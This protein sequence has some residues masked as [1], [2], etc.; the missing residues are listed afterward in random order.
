MSTILVTGAN[1]QLGSDISASLSSK[2][3]KVIACTRETFNLEDHAQTENVLMQ[4]KPEIVINTAA[5]HHVEQCEADEK[6][7]MLM[8][9]ET[10]QLMARVCSKINSRLIHFSTDYVFDGKKN[11]PYLET[12]ATAPLNVYGKSKRAGE[13]KIMNEGEQHLILRVS[14]LYGKHPCR[15]KNGLN[16]VQ[17]MLKLAREK[18]EVKVVNDEFVSPTYT[19]NIA[20]IMPLLIRKNLSGIVHLTSEG[21]CSW[22]EFAKE[23]FDYTQTQV[24][25]YEA[26]SSDFPAKVN[27]PKY[28]VLENA[29]LKKSGIR[30]MMHWKEALHSYLDTNPHLLLK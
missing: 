12:D 10:P 11:E 3:F 6:K 5:F 18:G 28:S 19:L 24:Q 30:N 26:H 25:L 2:G 9:A 22:H 15:A 29:T 21:S 27:R 1:G 4:I 8:N 13:E 16:F 7:A 23:I 17:L 20:D 14:A